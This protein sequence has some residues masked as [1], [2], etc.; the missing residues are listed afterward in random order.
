[1]PKPK[2]FTY[3]I[4][5]RSM[6]SRRRSN[7]ETSSADEEITVGQNRAQ[8][9][10]A[11]AEQSI[12]SSQNTGVNPPRHQDGASTSQ[13]NS[14]GTT[15][16]PVPQ[17]SYY[18]TIK[19]GLDFVET[20]NRQTYLNNAY[21][22]RKVLTSAE[23]VRL[24]DYITELNLRDVA[25]KMMPP[26][27]NEN[28]GAASV[29]DSGVSDNASEHSSHA[30]RHT[31]ASRRPHHSRP[32]SPSP[33]NR[34]TSPVSSHHSSVSSH[35]SRSGQQK[36]PTD[37][38]SRPRSSSSSSNTT[39]ADERQESS[40]QQNREQQQPFAES[41][42]T[43]GLVFD[44]IMATNLTIAL[45]NM[46]TVR[47][48]KKRTVQFPKGFKN[49]TGKEGVS[50]AMSWWTTFIN[51]TSRNTYTEEELICS[52]RDLMEIGSP[53]AKWFE[54]RG[55]KCQ[56]LKELE[57]SFKKAYGPS[58]SKLNEIKQ[59]VKSQRQTHDQS[60]TTFCHS[61]LMLNE[62][63]G[64][65]YAQPKLAKIIY[66]N[67]LAIYQVEITEGECSTV[68]DLENK[69][70][71]LE[72]KYLRKE[73]C[74]LE[75]E[76]HKIS[77]I[78]TVEQLY[79]FQQSLRKPSH[80]T[81]RPIQ[82]H[83]KIKEIQHQT[84][85]QKSGAKSSGHT[86]SGTDTKI[87]AKTYSETH[88]SSEGATNRRFNRPFTNTFPPFDVQKCFKP[89]SND[90]GYKGD[91]TKRPGFN[92]RANCRRCGAN[93]FFVRECPKCYPESEIEKWKG[94]GDS[95]R[96]AYVLAQKMKRTQDIA[97]KNRGSDRTTEINHIP[98]NQGNGVW[99]DN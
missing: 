72:D 47:E 4:R 70:S 13:G 57:V 51:F 2:N 43:A 95:E 39:I 41:T 76:G 55:K 53:A 73:L 36:G 92:P 67:M 80:F 3:Q 63:L 66:R 32:R 44:Q 6:S 26:P 62:E 81:N 59:N 25:R 84:Q 79:D 54:I 49:F 82:D 50:I 18:E 48:S 5:T 71:L 61:I 31:R 30:S 83:T 69:V 35:Q 52:V 14:A 33:E 19:E 94:M 90:Q 1:M 68:E 88:S 23:Y 34:N 10:E 20:K 91:L 98:R 85:T 28:S 11:S 74:Y 78:E 58:K 97:N 40:G 16:V 86:T 24:S 87:Q 29:A 7:S 15:R 42:Q 21:H 38:G 96:S 45:A 8:T 9:G 17:P 99:G 77:H 64:T 37:H 89:G 75:R 46:S 27:R 93:G 65:P 56:T 22:K 60:F 12:P